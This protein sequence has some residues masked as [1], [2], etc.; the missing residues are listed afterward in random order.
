MVCDTIF[1]NFDIMKMIRYT[2]VLLSALFFLT[3]CQKNT[4][5][6][7]PSI[8]FLGVSPD[9]LYP[10]INDSCFIVFSLTDG[11]GDIG[12][13]S[14]S[15]VWYRDRRADTGAFISSVFPA[16]NP[17]VE[18]PKKGLTGTCTF[19]PTPGP[20]PRPDSIHTTIADTVT[21]EV[22]ITDRAG[23]VSNHIITSPIILLP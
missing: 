11:D 16:I 12:N 4:L 3:T 7:I 2:L 9:T 23:H 10:K 6:K 17:A 8:F 14:T 1:G 5:S 21:Y 19:Y 15:Q 22:Y 20:I 13:S 18:D